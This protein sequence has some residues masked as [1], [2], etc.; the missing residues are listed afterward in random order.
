MTICSWLVKLK[1][2]LGSRTC[3]GLEFCNRS[4]RSRFSK[5]SRKSTPRS[6]KRRFNSETDKEL[7][8]VPVV[9]LSDA[10]AKAGLRGDELLLDLVRDDVPGRK[11]VPGVRSMTR[12]VMVLFMI[13]IYCLLFYVSLYCHESL[14]LESLL[15]SSLLGTSLTRP[16]QKK[17]RGRNVFTRRAHRGPAAAHS[18][19]HRAETHIFHQS[20][21]HRVHR[22]LLV[23]KSTSTVLLLW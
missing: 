10:V 4:T 14:I 18:E 5:Q 8:P 6:L 22:A 15:E 20:W 19:P 3:K 2:E 23:F 9:E 11:D 1:L 13:W 12:N 16:T 21:L 7:S 17:T